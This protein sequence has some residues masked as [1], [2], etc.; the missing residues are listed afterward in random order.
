M[1]IR[2]TS[3]ARKKVKQ[4]RPERQPKPVRGKGKNK[5][6]NE[7]NVKGRWK[8]QEGLVPGFVSQNWQR[9]GVRVSGMSG[10]H[11]LSVAFLA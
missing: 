3:R 1:G 9:N 2:N 6:D 11:C 7:G 8:L 5:Q 10:C 4:T